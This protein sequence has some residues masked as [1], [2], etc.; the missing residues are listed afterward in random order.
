MLMDDDRCR[1]FKSEC[2]FAELGMKPYCS[3]ILIRVG[4]SSKVYSCPRATS[5]SGHAILQRGDEPMIV[6]DSRLDW[7]F[8]KSVSDFF[9]GCW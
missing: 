4:G 5:F 6:L 2:A 9:F 3:D 8:A 7:R 1:W